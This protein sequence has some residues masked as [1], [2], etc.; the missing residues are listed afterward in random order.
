MCFREIGKQHG[1]TDKQIAEYGR[2]IEM[3]EQME[4]ERGDA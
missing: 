4:K 1:Y 2:Y 3:A